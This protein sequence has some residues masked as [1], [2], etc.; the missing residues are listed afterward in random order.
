[1]HIVDW[2]PSLLR[3]AGGSA[4]N[5]TSLDGFDLWDSLMEDKESPRRV[6]L[7]NIDDIVGAAAITVDQWKLIKGKCLFLTFFFP[8]FRLHLFFFDNFMNL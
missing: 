4:T 7:H 8:L 5:A 6:V 3:A 1:M 2:L